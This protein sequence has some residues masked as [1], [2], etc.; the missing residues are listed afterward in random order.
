[1]QVL[2]LLSTIIVNII[3]YVSNLLILIYILALLATR[4]IY[5]YSCH[6]LKIAEVETLYSEVS[7]EMSFPVN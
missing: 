7:K 3:D 4:L 6:I 2:L 1:M 5:P